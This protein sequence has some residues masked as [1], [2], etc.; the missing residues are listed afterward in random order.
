MS[1]SWTL[2]EQICLG[3]GSGQARED[4][5][6]EKFEDATEDLASRTVSNASSRSDLS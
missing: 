3:S 5:E 6:S 1:Q 2:P 4:G